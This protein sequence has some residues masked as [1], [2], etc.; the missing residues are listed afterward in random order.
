MSF[1]TKPENEGFQ[2]SVLQLLSSTQ[3]FN[4]IVTG[5]DKTGSLHSAGNC[6]LRSLGKL[7]GNIFKSIK[8]VWNICS[9]EF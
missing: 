3:F 9:Q 4:Q 8:V 7:L 2:Y 1:F 6:F 5:K